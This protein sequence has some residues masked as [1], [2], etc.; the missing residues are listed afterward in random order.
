MKIT[1]K[2]AKVKALLEEKNIYRDDYNALLARVWWDE[3]KNSSDMSAMDFLYLL[4][5]KR[6]SH[7][8]SIMR[9]RRKIQEEH[10]ILRGKT[11]KQRKTKEVENVQKE[12][13][14]GS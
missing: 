6:I 4:K 14:Y 11:Y 2:Y 7:P 5:A 1:E 8:E 13:G 10:P 12:L 3:I 9:V